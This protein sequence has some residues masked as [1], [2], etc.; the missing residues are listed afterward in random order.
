MSTEH[1]GITVG[2][3]DTSGTCH[4]IPDSHCEWA[5]RYFKIPLPPK[6]QNEGF[7]FMRAGLALD[8][9]L[10][11]QGWVKIHINETKNLL[12]FATRNTPW[13]KMSHR[14]RAWIYE[15]A[16]FNHKIQSNKIIPDISNR[17]YQLKVQFGNNDSFLSPEQLKEQKV[18]MFSEIMNRV[19]YERMTFGQLYGGSESGR[20]ERG[21]HDVN[22]KS[23]Q[24]MATDNGEAWTFNYKSNPSTTDN[25]WHGF[26]QFFKEDVSGKENAAD[27]ECKVDCDCPDYRYRYSYNNKQADV[28]WTGKHPEWKHSNDNNGQK[29]KPRSQGGV[30]DYGVGLCKHL[31]ALKEYLHTVIEPNAPEPDDKIQPSVKKTAQKPKVPL[32][33]APL[34]TK[35]PKPEDTYSDSRAGSDTLQE[36]Q[37]SQ[38]Y[39]K[40][41]NFV[42]TTPQFNVMM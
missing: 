4:F 22:A 27:L 15:I 32:S 33:Q 40:I 38:L 6:K 13:Q 5:S 30:G 3:L 18:P 24:V 34:T 39:K 36:G 19:L 8:N 26:I 14:Q 31:C 23:T 9:K 42:K 11:D 17:K 16:I 20:K 35:A 1:P 7:D 41:D 28:G 29:W 37:C 10:F 21:E 25:R 12:Y 2:W